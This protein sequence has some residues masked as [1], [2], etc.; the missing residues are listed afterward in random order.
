MLSKSGVLVLDAAEDMAERYFEDAEIR[1]KI[2]YHRNNNLGGTLD[3]M[4][5]RKAQMLDDW[6]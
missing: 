2:P 6:L 3:F 4:Q 5:E 1:S